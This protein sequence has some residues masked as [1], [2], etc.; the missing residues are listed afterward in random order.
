[1]S[2]YKSLPKKEKEK[3]KNAVFA[4]LLRKG[5]PAEIIPGHNLDM[6]HCPRCNRL[7]W[8]IDYITKHCPG[9]GQALKVPSSQ[10]VVK[11]RL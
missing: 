10:E 5:I 7:F 6:F 3:V 2:F 8:S 4:D 1:M 9:C 11:R